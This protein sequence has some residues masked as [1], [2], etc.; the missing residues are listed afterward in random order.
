MTAKADTNQQS[1]ERE[2]TLTRV[3]AAP[4]A[5]V[6]Q[7]WTDP[8]HLAQ[9]W[10]PDGFTNPVCEVDAR[11]GG[12][13]RIVMRA[14]DGAEYPMAGVF[15]EVVAPERLVF[16]NSPVDANGNPLMEGLTTVTFAE[17]GGKTTMTVHT[18]A[19]ALDPTAAW[20]LKGMDAGWTQMIER[21]VAYVARAGGG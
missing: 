16:T 1:L 5:L 11:A 19:R 21:L 2:L 13:L 12:S 4:R 18:R 17:S 3:F 9:W 14:P 15:H 20:M 6:F 8:K 10:G 7:A